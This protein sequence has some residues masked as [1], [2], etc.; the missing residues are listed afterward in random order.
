M[1]GLESSLSSDQID[2]IAGFVVGLDGGTAAA[3]PTTSP[4][5]GAP[6]TAQPSDG[7]SADVAGKQMSQEKTPT[8]M[9]GPVRPI[10]A[11]SSPPLPRSQS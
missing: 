2:E 11:P 10:G 7:S 3:E 4:G 8:R 9:L 6:A 5:D 1:P